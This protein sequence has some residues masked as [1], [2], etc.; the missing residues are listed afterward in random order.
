MKITPELAG[1]Q[2]GAAAAAPATPSLAND[3][4]AHLFK[5]KKGKG[6]STDGISQGV[7]AVNGGGRQVR[8]VNVTIQSL[9]K[10]VVINSAGGVR[11][12]A[13]QIRQEVERAL[14]QAVQ[15]GELTMAND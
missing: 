12:S 2:P 4:F 7:S 9:V 8:N 3:P 13:M 10:Q 11:E 6:S 1:G 15:G 5:D 14:I